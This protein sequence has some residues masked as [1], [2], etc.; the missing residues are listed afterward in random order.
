MYTQLFLE[1]YIILDKNSEIYYKR[2]MKVNMRYNLN[3]KW[4]RKKP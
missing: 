2:K 1:S 3:E 4:E